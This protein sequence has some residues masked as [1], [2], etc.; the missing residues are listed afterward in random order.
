MTLRLFVQSQQRQRQVLLV[1]CAI[2]G[3]AQWQEMDQLHM[4]FE[5]DM[6]W[7]TQTAKGNRVALHSSLTCRNTQ[8]DN[9]EPLN[10]PHCP[11]G[12][13]S[14]ILK[15]YL[16][17]TYRLLKKEMQ[18]QIKLMKNRS[19]YTLDRMGYALVKIITHVWGFVCELKRGHFTCQLMVAASILSSRL[20][21]K[22]M[23]TWLLIDAKNR[24][25]GKKIGTFTNNWSKQIF[26]RNAF[27]ISSA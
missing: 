7:P 3:A 14:C 5:V 4:V 10:A 18:M 11:L 12:R 23:P 1:L 24:D 20:N 27:L 17:A 16:D 15:A 6:R 22:F 8:G 26:G 19:Q 9:E 25:T 13:I 2:K 21:K